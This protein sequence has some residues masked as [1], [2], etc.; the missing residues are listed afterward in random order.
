MMHLE[1]IRIKNGDIILEADRTDIF[2]P[3]NL[4]DAVHSAI[5]DDFRPITLLIQGIDNTFQAWRTAK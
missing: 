2:S 1:T 5:A 3:D 4:L